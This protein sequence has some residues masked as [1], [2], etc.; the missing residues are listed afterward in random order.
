[1]KI[2]IIEALG[3]LTNGAAEFTA[4]LAHVPQPGTLIISID[5][6]TGFFQDFQAE[7]A[8]DGIAILTPVAENLGSATFD[9]NT[10]ELNIVLAEAAAAE[11]AENAEAATEEAPAAEETTEAEA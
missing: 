11:A 8:K 6:H 4:T 2:I 10:K 7:K 1:M 5:G 9:Y 3:T